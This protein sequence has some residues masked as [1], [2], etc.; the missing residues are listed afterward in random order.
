MKNTLRIIINR[1]FNDKN[2]R[3]SSR[4]VGVKLPLWAMVRGQSSPRILGKIPINGLNFR[5]N[6]NNHSLSANSLYS[7]QESAVDKVTG[8]VAFVCFLALAF[9]ALGV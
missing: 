3:C 5:S 8:V 7:P 1:Y 6:F 9:L 2:T 4:G